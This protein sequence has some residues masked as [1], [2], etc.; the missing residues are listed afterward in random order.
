[1]LGKGIS[2]TGRVQAELQMSFE[3]DRDR[4]I[5]PTLLQELLDLGLDTHELGHLDLGFRILP[6]LVL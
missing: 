1:V 4:L 2:D 5:G 3:R 6:T